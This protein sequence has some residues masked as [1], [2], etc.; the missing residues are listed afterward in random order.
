M[1]GIKSAEPSALLQTRFEFAKSKIFHRDGTGGKHPPRSNFV[2]AHVSGGLAWRFYGR[3]AISD[4][5]F[6]LIPQFGCVLMPMHCE[7]VLYSR[8]KQFALC[9]GDY[10]NCASHFAWD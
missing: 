1:K 8:L 2:W 4:A 9:V 6:K 3:H 7:G 10:C 5:A